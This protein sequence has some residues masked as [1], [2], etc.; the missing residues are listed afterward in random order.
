MEDRRKGMDDER[1]KK[2]RNV[3]FT[4]REGEA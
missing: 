3:R 2:R 1:V 4:M